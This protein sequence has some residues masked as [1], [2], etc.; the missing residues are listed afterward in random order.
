MTKPF[1]CYNAAYRNYGYLSF[2]SLCTQPPIACQH[3]T[4]ELVRL[5]TG[6]TIQLFYCTLS[7][8]K[9]AKQK[10]GYIGLSKGKKP[11]EATSEG[12]ACSLSGRR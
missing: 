8:E 10:G 5:K 6:K 12:L 4:W 9:P 2:Q 1:I 3:E 7:A 11:N